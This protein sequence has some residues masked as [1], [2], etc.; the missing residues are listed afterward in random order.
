MGPSFRHFSADEVGTGL[1]YAREELHIE[2][3]F[4]LLRKLANDTG[5]R[6]YKD[7]RKTK[8]LKRAKSEI[9]LAAL[10]QRDAGE[11]ERRDAYSAAIGKMFSTRSHNAKLQRKKSKAK[12]TRGIDPTLIGVSAKGQY[13]LLI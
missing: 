13:E 5:V 1:R 2:L 4:D 9:L 11:S 8:L 10:W 6:W 7:G 12:E 3:D